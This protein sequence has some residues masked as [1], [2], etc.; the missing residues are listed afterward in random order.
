MRYLLLVL[1]FVGTILTSV[2]LAQSSNPPKRE[3]RGAWIAT[4]ANIDWPSQPGLPVAQQQAQLVNILDQLKAMGINAVFFQ[5]RPECDALYQSNIEPWSYWLT[6]RQGQAPVPF[7]DPL[8]FAIQEAHKRGMELHAWF[9]PYRALRDTTQSYD[10]PD[11]MHVT[12]RH[13]DWILKFGKLKILNPGLPQVRDYITS[14]IMDVVRRY[15]IDGVHFDDYFYPYEGIQKQDTATFRLYNRGFTDIG[16]WRRDNVNLFVKEVHDSIMAVKSWVKF[17]ISPFGIWRPNFPPGIG[18]LDAYNQLYADA[19]AWLQQKTVDYVAPQL[20]WPNGGGQDYAKLM[21]WWADSA[22]ANGRQVYIGQAAY[23]IPN[24]ASGEMERQIRQNRA[25]GKVVGSI[26]FNT[27]S[28]ISNLGNF[29]DSLKQYYYRYPALIP[30]MAW[31]GT[32]PPNEPTN[33]QYA[34]TDSGGPELSW[35]LPAPAADGDTASR[36][37]VYRFDHSNISSANIDSAQNILLVSGTTSSNLPIPPGGGPYYYTVTALDRNWNESQMTNVIPVYSPPVPV[38]AFPSD[39]FMNARDTTNL[40]WQPSTLAA[41]YSLVVSTDSAFSKDA[42][43]NLCGIAADSFAITGMGGM[44]RYF[45]KVSAANAGGTSGF[46]NAW[47]FTTGFPVAPLLAGPDSL[48]TDVLL[49]PAFVWHP[50][51]STTKYRLQ[52]TK[53]VVFSSPVIDTIISSDTSF[54]LADS[55]LGNTIYSWRVSSGNAYGFSMWS[56]TW[57]FRT[58]VPTWI[59]LTSEAATQFELPQN[60]PNPFNP[61][62]VISYQLSAVGYVTLKV[63]DVLGREVET[64]VNR[65]QNPGSHTVTFDASK[66]PSGVYF[67]RLNAGTYTAT[68]K[69]MVIK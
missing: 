67:Y 29:A 34:M 10:N 42:L 31:K 37:V 30:Q 38:L 69:M 17:G 66:L 7:Y 9:N 26:Y 45:W 28:L 40:Q 11:T 49:L 64:L 16:D 1:I 60:Y 15:D 36:F 63:Y 52:V 48:L 58:M 59:A 22:A 62:T 43:V 32:V 33:L 53:G 18:G 4:V 6:G 68:R 55:L 35:N 13:P 57:K 19:M 41:S 14:V 50:T 5:I 46:S 3:F 39:N 51:E 27:S 21:P 24:W 54:A 65:K 8:Q 25:N 44:Q 2:S 20:Y 61:T 56:N 23:R 47:S 12:V